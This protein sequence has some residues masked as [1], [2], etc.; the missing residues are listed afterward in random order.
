MR[1]FL[2]PPMRGVVLQSYG[3]GNGPDGRTEIL[4]LL[5]EACDRGVL[6]VNISQCAKGR[7][8]SGY[9]T[10]KV[11]L[12]TWLHIRKK[13]K[14]FSYIVGLI[15][16]GSF[17]HWRHSRKWLDTGSGPHEIKLYSL[18][19][20]LGREKETN[21]EGY[22]KIVFAFLWRHEH[23]CIRRWLG[24]IFGARCRYSRQ[25]LSNCRSLRN[26]HEPWTSPRMR[27]D[28]DQSKPL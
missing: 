23:V 17:G 14:V 25:K 27:S 21:C 28:V 5:K 10:G 2:Q 19:R 9:A 8:S 18:K 15:V 6:I 20:R 3:A 4:E 26:L 11:R 22:V 12:L 13:W 7:V 1:A 16:E 24:R